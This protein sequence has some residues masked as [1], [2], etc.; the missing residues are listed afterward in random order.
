MQSLVSRVL[1]QTGDSSLSFK[2]SMQLHVT[3]KPHWQGRAHIH[4]RS[5]V[6][7]SFGSLCL[8][9][10]LS[11]TSH[12]IRLEILGSQLKIKSFILG[13]I[14]LNKCIYM[15]WTCLVFSHFI[16]LVYGGLLWQL[17]WCT[18]FWL[19]V[20]LMFNVDVTFCVIHLLWIILFCYPSEWFRGRSIYKIFATRSL[21]Q[22]WQLICNG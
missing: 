7:F 18:N 4:W 13:S 10:V 22:P 12:I 20:S 19:S 14:S 9:V 3:A 11:P 5:N 2:F 15:M 8:M 21:T 16:R 17:P 1:S 6:K